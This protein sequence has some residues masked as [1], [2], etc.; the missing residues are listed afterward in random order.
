MWSPSLTEGDPCDVH[1]PAKEKP[2]KQRQLSQGLIMKT[3]DVV[4]LLAGAFLAVVPARL[5]SAIGAA[6]PRVAPATVEQML[7]DFVADF[8]RDPLAQEPIV[9]GIRVKDA[10]SRD[11]H[12]YVGGGEAERGEAI[13]ELAEGLPLDPAAYFVTDLETL[14]SI[15]AGEL[16]SLTAMGKAF[17]T[18]FAPLDIENMPGFVPSDEVGGHLTRLSFHFWTR[19]LPELIR[20]G[21]AARTRELHGGN[22]VLLYYQPGFRSGWFRIDPGQHVNE[23]EAMQTNTFPTMLIAT[24]GGIHCRIG[25][26]QMKLEENVAVLIGAGVSHEFWVEKGEEPS[27]GILLMFGEGA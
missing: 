18:D 13:V 22:G 8:R 27:E 1:A 17:S 4:Y 3:R 11:W 14:R 15:H 16:A 6:S 5:V 9:F 2:H 20:I 7:G 12:V 21:D 19:G 25:G 10:P 24:K 26:E 23:P